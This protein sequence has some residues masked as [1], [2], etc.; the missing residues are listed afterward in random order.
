MKPDDRA[1]EASLLSTPA[2]RTSTKNE[3]DDDV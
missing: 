3:S 2:A 1:R